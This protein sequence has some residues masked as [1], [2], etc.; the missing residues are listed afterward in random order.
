M[1]TKIDFSEFGIRSATKPFF[2]PA[3]RIITD[4]YAGYEVQIKRWWSPFFIQ[5]G[6]N[7]HSSV[8]HCQQFIEAHKRNG[9]PNK[10]TR[11]VEENIY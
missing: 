4:D 1:S 3:Y 11:I 9:K 10:R 8:T 7:T 6:I 5:I 2:A